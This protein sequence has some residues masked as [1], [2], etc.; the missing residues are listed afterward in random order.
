LGDLK[1]E[2][3][4][5]KWDATRRAISKSSAGGHAFKHPSSPPP[6]QHSAILAAIV[7]TVISVVTLTSDGAKPPPPPP[8]TLP[9]LIEEKKYKDMGVGD[10]LSI[11]EGDEEAMIRIRG[12][13]GLRV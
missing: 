6:L 3:E 7:F 8:A 4:Q 10:D 9:P 12:L 1:T 5:A 13:E 2:I 11:R